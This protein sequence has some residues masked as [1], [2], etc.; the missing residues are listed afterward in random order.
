MSERKWVLAI[1]EGTT[2]ATALVLDATGRVRGRGAR[3]IP[4]HFPR[5]GWVEHEP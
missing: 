3:E 2:G 1:D 4:Q 5:A